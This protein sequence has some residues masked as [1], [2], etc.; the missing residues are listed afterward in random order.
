MTAES[1]RIG[2][3]CRAGLGLYL[4]HSGMCFCVSALWTL[5]AGC[6]LCDAPA[7]RSL[8]WEQV[9]WCRFSAGW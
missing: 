2:S 3:F 8:T 5:A 6:Q 9:P 4:A 1:A 7:V